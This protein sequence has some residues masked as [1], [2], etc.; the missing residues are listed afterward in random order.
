M[1]AGGDAGGTAPSEGHQGG[2]EP[3]R[4]TKVVKK[5]IKRVKSPAVV[6]QPKVPTATAKSPAQVGSTTTVFMPG[7]RHT[8]R[9]NVKTFFDPATH[10]R[11]HDSTDV[12]PTL[13]DLSQE[14]PA[15]EVPPDQGGSEDDQ[16]KAGVEGGDEKN[17]FGTVDGTGGGTELD[18]E[19]AKGDGNDSDKNITP[20]EIDTE[21]D[22]EKN[23]GDGNDSD[24]KHTPVETGQEGEK[25][26]DDEN[27]EKPQHTP[28]DPVETGLKQDEEKNKDE[29]KGEDQKNTPVGP[30]ETDLKQDDE[31]NVGEKGDD[32]KEPTAKEFVEDLEKVLEESANSPDD[33]QWTDDKW[34]WTDDQWYSW[35]HWNNS[36]YRWW[37]S[38]D[39]DNHE[40]DNLWSVKRH[41]QQGT[42]ST[43]VSSPSTIELEKCLPRASTVDLATP[44][45][46]GET[47]EPTKQDTNEA[48][49]ET[50]TKEQLETEKEIA[51]KKAHA[52]YMR[53][54]RSVHE[55]RD[56]IL[57]FLTFGGDDEKITL[58]KNKI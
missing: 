57:F 4:R 19:K 46:T 39:R 29:E 30:V 48:T 23:K 11:P 38:W 50:K 31:K 28:V 12:A 6:Q 26:N 13:Q 42:P 27:M 58:E 8:T 16:N 2:A 15:S 7:E 5:I 54:Y 24:K 36:Y 35:N 25:K 44:P 22:G 55:S 32:Q 47:G 37:G 40:D 3:K 56:L 45:P 17:Q 43:V 51:R 18:G 14:V 41:G 52:R 9:E 1:R 10:R 53:Y 33:Q 34:Q 20:V 21:L 49:E